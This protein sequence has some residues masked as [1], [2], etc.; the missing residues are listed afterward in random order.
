MSGHPAVQQACATPIS[1]PSASPDSMSQLQ[2][3]QPEAL[4]SRC[5]ER[6]DTLCR[7][8]VSVRANSESDLKIKDL[9]RNQAA[10]RFRPGTSIRS[11]PVSCISYIVSPPRLPL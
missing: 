11:A 7:V 8:G 5:G 9:I 4:G 3:V 6:R 1:M 10:I 2:Y